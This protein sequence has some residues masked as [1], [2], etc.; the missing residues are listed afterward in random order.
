MTTMNIS[1][2]DE[3]K[4]F[5]DEQIATGDF[6]TSSEFIRSLIRREKDV[7]KLRKTLMDGA[8]SGIAE[9]VDE[10]YFDNLRERARN[11]EFK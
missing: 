1:L 3:L 10:N 2:T 11:G 7:H 5:V 8:N 4:A 9:T 6:T